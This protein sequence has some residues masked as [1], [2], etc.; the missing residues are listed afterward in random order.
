MRFAANLSPFSGVPEIQ[1][2]RFEVVGEF[3]VKC[4]KRRSFC[5]SAD[6]GNNIIA[7][8]GIVSPHYTNGDVGIKY[9]V[10]VI[11]AE[12]AFTS[13]SLL[14]GRNVCRVRRDG[15]VLEINCQIVRQSGNM[16]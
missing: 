16:T 12:A 7:E 15:L 14:D 10:P 9:G 13:R 5:D 6:R 2:E 4:N 8:I 11:Q 1:T 3:S